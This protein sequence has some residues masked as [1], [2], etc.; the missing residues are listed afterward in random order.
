M[1]SLYNEKIKRDKTPF[2]ALT[3][4]AGITLVL[5]SGFARR[6]RISSTLLVVADIILLA[7]FLYLA[8]RLHM[9]SKT[10]LKYSLISDELLVHKM[11]GG[12]VKLVERVN[13]KDVTDIEKVNCISER[14]RSAKSDISCPI[15]SNTYRITFKGG[16][17]FFRPSEPMLRKIKNA[18]KINKEN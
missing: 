5:I 8:Y 1:A 11:C 18:V 12:N 7:I 17:M 6:F 15:V 16:E 10:A 9:S 13:L 3:A 2:I 4:L 14:I